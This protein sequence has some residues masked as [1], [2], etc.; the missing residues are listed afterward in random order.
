MTSA[1]ASTCARGAYGITTVRA[2][3]ELVCPARAAER[4]PQR[5]EVAWRVIQRC[6]TIRVLVV[7]VETVAEDGCAIEAW[8]D[9]DQQREI[10]LPRL[11][12][13]C[14]TACEGGLLHV[15]V[16]HQGDRLLAL[17][18]R[19]ADG[20]LLFSQTS[21]LARLGFAG[22]SYDAPRA[23]VTPPALQAP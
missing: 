18:M 5:V 11:E 19:E 7:V 2:P 15:D 8:I 12:T 6:R 13:P 21:L 10:V 1:S 14:V 22:G 20:E 17:S 3:L 23:A 4:F 16:C 9:K